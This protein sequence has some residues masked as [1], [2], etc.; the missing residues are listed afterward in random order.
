MSIKPIGAYGI[1]NAASIFIFELDQDNDKI[2]IG[3]NDKKPY[4]TDL[5]TDEYS[6]YFIFGSL[7]ID[8]IEICRIF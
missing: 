5:I 7:K 6:T 2:L 4:W 1:C 8:L 3:L